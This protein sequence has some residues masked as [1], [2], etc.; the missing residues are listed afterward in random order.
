MGRLGMG[1]RAL[2]ACVMASA[3]AVGLW[4][5]A[6]W[7]AGCDT[8]L[9]IAKPAKSFNSSVAFDVYTVTGA[10][11]NLVGSTPAQRA[12]ALPDCDWSVTPRAPVD[13]DKVRQEVQFQEI[14]GLALRDS[15]DADLAHLKGLTALQRRDLSYTR[16]TDAGL[17]NLKGMSG[18]QCLN[19]EGTKVTDAGLACLKGL[20]ALQQLSLGATHIA[21][22][23]LECLKGLTALQRLDLSDTQ[24]TDAGLVYL[25]GMKGL[26]WID[27]M[28]TKVTD[29][30]VGR[31]KAAL[32]Y[33]SVTR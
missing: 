5:V 26:L 17:V 9:G 13:M 4:A 29:A 31:M 32:P 33:V 1:N 7:A 30:G 22:G 6:L 8:P 24:V 19:L 21:D 15:T 11:G 16:V 3:L 10:R 2:K 14:P 28:G 27:L 25:K 23:G 20:T 12:L 18:L